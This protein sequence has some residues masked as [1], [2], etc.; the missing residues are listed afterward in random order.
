MVS[1]SYWWSSRNT[2]L[3]NHFIPYW[4]VPEVKEV[5][6]ISQQVQEFW[7]K[8]KI[9][10][11]NANLIK[12]FSILTEKI[13]IKFLWDFC[14]F[15]HLWKTKLHRHYFFYLFLKIEPMSLLIWKSLNGYCIV[16]M[17]QNYLSLKLAI[18]C[19]DLERFQCN[20]P[21]VFRFGFILILAM[22]EK[23]LPWI[24]ISPTD[25]ES[26]NM[27]WEWWVRPAYMM[28]LTA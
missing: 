5:V 24:T 21:C 28:Q 8:S 19:N 22:C 13:Q 17:I 14:F 2:C 9:Q 1:Y 6:E 12:F 11:K 4:F 25:S 26:A 27:D 3:P 10:L 7:I 18:V 16:S 20:R 15:W 23:A